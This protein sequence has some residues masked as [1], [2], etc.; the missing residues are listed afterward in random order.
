MQGNL[1]ENFKNVEK[2]Q[3]QYC[4]NSKNGGLFIQSNLFR[5]SMLTLKIF[6]RNGFCSQ[7]LLH[8]ITWAFA[9]VEGL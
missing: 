1:A 2:E 3:G 6:R 8:L 5:M 4:R 9:Y 7:G